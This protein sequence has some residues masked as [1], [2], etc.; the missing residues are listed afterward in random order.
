M[1][2]RDSVDFSIDLR[3]SIRNYFVVE[4]FF[5]GGLIAL[6]VVVIWAGILLFYVSQIRDEIRLLN[7][8]LRRLETHS[9][10][11]IDLTPDDL[12]NDLDSAESKNYW[13]PPCRKF[14]AASLSEGKCPICGAVGHPE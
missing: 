9:S 3:S 14:Y 10:T 12:E 4:D 1:A 5:I 7:R 11:A 13:C 8:L 6:L 2:E